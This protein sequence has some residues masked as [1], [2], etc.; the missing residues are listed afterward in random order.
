M[1]NSKISHSG[2]KLNK[3]HLNTILMFQKEKV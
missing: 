2:F 3:A 1:K